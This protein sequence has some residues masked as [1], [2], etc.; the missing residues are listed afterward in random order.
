MCILITFVV[1][2]T[3]QLP[4]PKVDVESFYILKRNPDYFEKLSYYE[5]FGMPSGEAV[6]S[7]YALTFI[8]FCTNRF[9]IPLFLNALLVTISSVVLNYHYV[10]QVVVG[11]FIGCILGSL[12]YFYC[13]DFIVNRKCS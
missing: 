12:L 5:M 6:I 9:D 4:V 11:A 13:N 2:L 3:L 1:K 8:S 10:D 7:L